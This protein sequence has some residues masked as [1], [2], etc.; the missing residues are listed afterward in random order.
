MELT[1]KIYP[2]EVFT[3]LISNNKIDLLGT[4]S[5]TIGNIPALSSTD[6]AILSNAKMTLHSAW[7]M[8]GSGT[9]YDNGYYSKITTQNQI[10]DYGNFAESE[11][12]EVDYGK[13]YVYDYTAF[14]NKIGSGAGNQ[15]DRGFIQIR[16]AEIEFCIPLDTDG[17]GIPDYL[18]L[19][20]D[21]DGCPDAIEGSANFTTSQ[22]TNASGII[23]SQSV[24]Q[25]FG[26]TVDT[27]GIPTTVGASGQGV[28][29]S[30]NEMVNDCISF[31]CP[32][33]PYAAQ[34][35]WWLPYYDEKVRIDFQSGSAVLNN[36]ATGFL[37]KG[38]DGGFEGNVAVTHPVTG[39]LLFV[40]DGNVVYKGS[41]GEKA[42]GLNVGGHPS[43]GEAAAVI[44]DPQG[45]LG[46]DFLIIGNSTYG[47]PGGLYMSRYNVAT[48]SLTSLTNLLGEGSINEGLEVI[49]HSNGEDYWVLVNTSDQK[50]KSFLF[51]KT[52][53]FNPSAISSTDVSDLPGVDPNSVA[54]NSHISWD[55]NSPGKILV[56]R[57]NKIGL[58]NF[59]PST[60][61]IGEWNVKI[62][63]TTG[64]ADND[65]NIG[66]S[67]ALSSNGQYIYYVAESNN[68]MAYNLQT[69]SSMQ[70]G[71]IPYLTGIKLGP[72]GKLYGVGYSPDWELRLF[73]YNTP[74][75]PT[76]STTTL[77]IFNTDGREISLQLPNNVYWGCM[78]CQSG[79]DAPILANTNIT[80]NP[81]T[82]GNLIA[83]LSASN[84]PVG[85]VITIH[86]DAIATDANR[87]SNSTAIV[88]GTTYY[89]SFYDGLAIC[90]SPTTS[91]KV[92][93]EFCYQ[94]GLTDSNNYPS[95]HGI[96]SLGRAGSDI[97]NW[98]M[99][100]QSAW[101]VLES[102]TKGFVI[103]R[104]QFNSNNEPVASDGTSLVITS[105]VEGMMVYDTTN[106]CLKVY[107]SKD[108]GNTYAWY[109]MTTQTC[110][111]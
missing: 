103:N 32:P 17:D 107:T 19:D 8:I 54:T 57:H 35:T 30:Q 111:E 101:T 84:L 22:L 49:P 108:A 109:C 73:Y 66:Y 50:L 94:P 25:N 11:Y 104:I 44:P 14:T 89:V 70:V 26:I 23:S 15:G 24:N 2:E 59:N 80:T 48:N 1:T 81:T 77:P 47:T 98:P 61:T 9:T 36:P 85:T 42:S 90:Y 86:S 88:A 79:N 18:D 20:S 51:S 91:I 93:E 83:L 43:A 37:G 16:F 31:I 67:A 34:Q 7:N 27:N 76:F 52:T 72:D 46:M 74:N 45:I 96:T 29:N 62:M 78:T 12:L 92:G 97:D 105:P 100:R 82:I 63:V 6:T 99:V 5:A 56:S 38:V 110:P 40:T 64:N 41:T 55:P 4:Y 75:S 53:G 33:D 102:K 87:L 10:V 71:T 95:K 28:G 39:E 13:T 106:N 58:V 65:S 21:N 3:E 69:S 68:L 60:G